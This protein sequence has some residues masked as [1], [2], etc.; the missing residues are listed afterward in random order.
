LVFQVSGKFSNPEFGLVF[1]VSGKYSN[2][3]FDSVFQVGVPRTNTSVSPLSLRER[4][5]VRGF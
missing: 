4:V 1:Q 3:E 2:P 5:R